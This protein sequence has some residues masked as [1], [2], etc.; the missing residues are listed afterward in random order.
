MSLTRSTSASRKN[1][2]SLKLMHDLFRRFAGVVSRVVGSGWTLIFVVLVIVGTG[3]YSDFGES[4]KDATDFG[5]KLTV[6]LLVFLLQ[7][8]QNHSDKATHLKL[9]E[10]IKA[11]EGARNEIAAAEH[12]AEKKMDGLRQDL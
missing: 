1:K 2:R 12:Q 6:L 9:D 8:S 4:W 3:F 11:S 7:K 10:L 5:A